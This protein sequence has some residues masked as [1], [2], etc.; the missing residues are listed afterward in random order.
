MPAYQ[1]YDYRSATPLPLGAQTI[2]LLYIDP[3]E[4]E[5]EPLQGQ[6]HVFKLQDAPK[7]S[8]LSYRWSEPNHKG[9]LRLLGG[10]FKIGENAED[11]LYRIR[12]EQ[13]RRRRPVYWI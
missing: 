12:E 7:F 1:A 4:D 8:A 5:D 3:S 13:S 10:L 11:A 6:L 9:G 2:R